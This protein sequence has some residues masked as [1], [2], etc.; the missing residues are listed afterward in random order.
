MTKRKRVDLVMRKELLTDVLYDQFI[1]LCLQGR[2]SEALVIAKKVNTNKLTIRKKKMFRGYIERFSSVFSKPKKIKDPIQDLT[3]IYKNYWH[4]ILLEN[5]RQKAFDKILLKQLK[6]WMKN[7]RGIHL[8]TNSMEKIVDRLK[9]EIKAMGYNCITGKVPPFQELEIWKT[10]K[11]VTYSVNL[12]EGTERVK[13]FLMSDFVIKGWLAYATM[14]R[15]YP[16]G[17]AKKEGLFCNTQAYDLR[18][19][20]FRVSFLAHEA[21]YY[22]D[23]KKFPGLGSADLEYRAKLAEFAL[24]KKTTQKVYQ[25]FASRAAYNKKSPHAFSSFCVIRDLTREI[26]G[27]EDFKALTRMPN[28]FLRRVNF[29]QAA[30]RLMK[31]HS[32]ALQSQGRRKVKN[33]IE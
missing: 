10:Q 8:K 30:V 20:K 7:V 24:A 12:P 29:S 3:C 25:L 16:G 33:F 18:S 4:H 6:E 19:E 23:Y 5:T 31:R 28:G 2:C 14:G 15:H 22:S 26:S 21:Q 32:Q 9:L 1:S 13:T 17:W 11:V 27:K